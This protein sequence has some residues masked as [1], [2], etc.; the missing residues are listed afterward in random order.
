V[1]ISRKVHYL[2]LV[3]RSSSTAKN[4]P[5]AR[6][7]KVLKEKRLKNGTPENAQALQFRII[8]HVWRSFHIHV[9]TIGKYTKINHVSVILT[10]FT[11]ARYSLAFI[12]SW[13][14]SIT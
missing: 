2:H 14:H 9:G 7:E 5:S 3:G 10:V 11:V 6:E 1:I 12:Y 8:V 4:K 13:F